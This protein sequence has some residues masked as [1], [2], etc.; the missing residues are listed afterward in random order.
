[1]RKLLISF[2]K[3]TAQV[4]NDQHT[5]LFGKYLLLTNTVSSGFLMYIG[6]YFAQRIQKSKNM[7][8]NGYDR[9]KMKQL[10]V[11]GLSQG[12]LHHYTYM[13]MERLLPGNAKSTIVKKIM[14][15]QFIVSPV[16]ILH[17][18]YTSYFLEGRKVT[19]TNELLKDKFLKVYVADWLVWPA[20]QFINFQ[21]V[22]LQYRVL[23]I[24]MI[25]MFY[26]I[27]LCYVKNER[28]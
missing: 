23:Y 28:H 9:E 25:T 2:Y 7:N 20:T 4:V 21:F 13:W 10:A 3:K 24:N 11:V 18:F 26:N 27:F 14:S 5:A 1:M 22:P 19:E 16:F 12:P 6:E 8:E 17:Y 15:D